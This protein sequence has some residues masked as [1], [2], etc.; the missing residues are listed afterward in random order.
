MRTSPAF[1]VNFSFEVIM[2]RIPRLRLRVDEN[3]D[4]RRHLESIREGP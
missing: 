3:H 1:S 2:F 4:C